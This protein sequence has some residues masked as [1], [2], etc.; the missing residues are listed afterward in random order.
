M[1]EGEW[2]ERGEVNERW[3]WRKEGVEKVAGG[4]FDGLK[5]KGKLGWRQRW[6]WKLV[7]LGE[8][9]IRKLCGSSAGTW[10]LPPAN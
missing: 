6:G 10:K 3:R 5:M 2:G 9:E 7:R 8:Q 1:L 4:Q